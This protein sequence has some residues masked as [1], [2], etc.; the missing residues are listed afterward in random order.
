[1]I[2]L[3]DPGRDGKDVGIENDVFRR[4]PNHIDQQPVGT[5]ANQLAPL[6]AVGL[7]LFVERHHHS[8]GTIAPA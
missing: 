7:T 2:V 5:L 3:I 6:K 4:K 8:R 1:M